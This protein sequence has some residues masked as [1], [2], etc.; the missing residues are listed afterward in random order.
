MYKTHAVQRARAASASDP[1]QDHVEP[2]VHAVVYDPIGLELKEL[3]VDLD[4]LD[5]EE[6]YKL[7]PTTQEAMHHKT[8][9]P[10]V[11]PEFFV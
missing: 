4:I 10:G 11:A 5:Y 6:V 2:R 8:G 1:S 3:A 9:S 7:Y